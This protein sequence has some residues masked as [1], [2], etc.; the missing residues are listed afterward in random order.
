M[1][2]QRRLAKLEGAVGERC[3]PNLAATLEAAMRGDEEA[4]RDLNAWFEQAR[5]ERRNPI[6]DPEFCAASC[7]VPMDAFVEAAARLGR[8]DLLPPAWRNREVG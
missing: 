6:H 7:A 2:M 3:K 5:R 4:G 8:M 1:R